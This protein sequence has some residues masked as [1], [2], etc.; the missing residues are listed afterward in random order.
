MAHV[1]KLSRGRLALSSE[2]T[3]RDCGRSR[4]RPSV[5][6]L[7]SCSTSTSSSSSSS[8]SRLA[9]G[10]PKPILVAA[11]RVMTQVARPSNP[12]PSPDGSGNPSSDV[13]SSESAALPTSHAPESCAQALPVAAGSEEADAAAAAVDAE[14][15]SSGAVP[16]A[17]SAT[18]GGGGGGA[19]GA[20]ASGGGGGA[21]GG[22]QSVALL[23]RFN[24]I[25]YTFVLAG[26]LKIVTVGGLA[27]SSPPYLMVPVGLGMAWLAKQV[28]DSGLNESKRFLQYMVG[29]L[30]LLYFG[31][32]KLMYRY[33]PDSEWVRRPRPRLPGPMSDLRAQLG[34]KDLLAG[35]GA[36][37]DSRSYQRDKP[38][39]ELYDDVA[40][41]EGRYPSQLGEG[42]PRGSRASSSA[43]AAAAAGSDT[44]ADYAEYAAG[45]DDYLRTRGA[46]GPDPDRAD[47]PLAAKVANRRS[48]LS[49]K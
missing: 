26:F 2:L 37:A 45:L 46:A 12:S 31:L 22:N 16:A 19:R 49:D 38:G 8:S 5:M 10:V 30:V 6:L 35:A 40:W 32:V 41:Y 4:S 20:T 1:S 42:R 11:R 39:Q 48:Y 24:G 43:R 47:R 17:P 23:T 15:G 29:V 33:Q 25:G 18:G 7:R 27:A 13:P 34:D 44:D 28:V 3:A 21:A 14:A 36:L 9:A